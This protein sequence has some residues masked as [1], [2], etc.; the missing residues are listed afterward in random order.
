MAG[1]VTAE[2]HVIANPA[3][4]YGYT[5][6]QRALSASIRSIV[7]VADR[8][9]AD[10]VVAA[11]ATDGRPVSTT[12]PL[13]ANNAALKGLE[14]RTG[15]LW[16]P[17]VPTPVLGHMGKTAGFQVITGLTKNTFTAAQILKGGVTFDDTN[18]W[19][20]APISG[21]YRISFQHYT[22]GD[23]AGTQI[24]TIYINTTQ[25]GINTR[26]YKEGYSDTVSHGS[27]FY[28]LAANDTVSLHSQ[29]AGANVSS[30]GTGGYNGTYVEIEYVCE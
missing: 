23:G 19:L 25:V 21:L 9:E 2:K 14:Y 11:M 6:E 10:T 30:W 29:H 8:T 7:S 5:A 16:R 20:V 27:G 4:T 26:Y 1:L 18:D 15:S 17:L 28:Q 13:Y 22:S 12:N 3:D 24:A